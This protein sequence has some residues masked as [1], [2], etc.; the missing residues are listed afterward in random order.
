MSR[1]QQL[2]CGSYC[3]NLNDHFIFSAV[4]NST[5]IH[6]EIENIAAK[7]TQ[8]YPFYDV[9]SYQAFYLYVFVELTM[10]YVANTTS[11][12]WCCYH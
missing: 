11:K 3:D 8:T 7:G 12:P 1:Y 4:I 6:H 5:Q 2:Y 9:F 10:L